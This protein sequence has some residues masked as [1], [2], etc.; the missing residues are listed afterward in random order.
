M[1]VDCSLRS[2]T[3]T[4]SRGLRGTKSGK[5]RFPVAARVDSCHSFYPRLT[6]KDVPYLKQAGKV[7]A[8]KV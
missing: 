7:K 8:Q 1:V 2:A 4:M 6:A 5:V 3:P